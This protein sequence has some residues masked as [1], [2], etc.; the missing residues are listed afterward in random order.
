MSHSRKRPVR[1]RTRRGML[2]ESLE[3]RMVMDASLSGFVFIDSDGDGVHGSG[4]DGLPGVEITLSGTTTG[5][6]QVE[7]SLLTG[8]DGSYQFDELSAGTYRISQRQPEA[9]VDGQESSDHSGAVV[10]SDQVSNLVVSANQNVAN[11]NFAERALKP[12]YVNM[13]WF[14]ASTPSQATML[15]ESVAKGEALAGNQ[16]LADAIR[17][18][19]AEA[20]PTTTD[21]NPNQND[22]PTVAA[23]AYTVAENQTLTV[24]ASNGVLKNDSDADGDSLSASVVSAPGNGTLTLATNGSFTY[25]P[26]ADFFGTDT[27]TY[28]VNDGTVNS[29]TATVTITVT[30]EVTSQNEFTVD[31]NAATGTFV[32]QVEA[33]SS[34]GSE[35]VF[36]VADSSVASQLRLLP[37]DHYTGEGDAAALLIEYFD[38]S[39]PHCADIHAVLKQL[40]TSFSSDLLV[41]RRHLVLENNGTPIF[42][43][44]EAAA[45]A[46]EAAGRQGKFDGMVDLLLT[47]QDDWRSAA[48]PATLFNSYAQQLQLDMNQFATDQQDQAIVDRIDRDRASAADLGLS[49]TPSFFLNG[50]A[51]SNPETLSAFTTVIQTEVDSSDRV[52]ALDR[53]TGDIKVADPDSLDFETTPTFEFT[54]NA[55]GSGSESIDVTVDLFDAN[56][57]APVAQNDSY[58]AVA[59]TE[60]VVNAADGVLANDTDADSQTLYATLITTPGN[61]AVTLNE[62][63]SF[64]Y[65]PD[66]GFTGTDTFTYRA[67]DGNF[68]TA[69]VT[70]TI[71]VG[72]APVATADAYS[73]GE[74]Q[75][76]TVNAANGVLANDT[77]PDSGTLTAQ[78]ASGPSHGSLTL[79]SDG[80][81]T[82]VPEADF[83]G[84]DSFTYQASDG[85]GFSSP[86][87]V[88]ITVTDQNTF[89][90]NENSNAGVLVGTI[91]P[92]S[93][94]GDTVIFEV[95]DPN[96]P[97]ELRLGAVDHLHGDAAAPVVLIEYLDLSCPHCAD[98]HAALKQL[99]TEFAGE[100]LV[101]RRHLLLFNSSTNSFVFPN[102]EEAAFVAE[103][104][105]RQG[106][107]DEMVDL[108]FTNQD[109]WRALADPTSVFNGYA[110]QLGLD[111]TQFA[112][113]QQ[114]ANLEARI[115]RDRTSASN[116]G[117]TSTPS[118]F[119]N[120]QSISNPETV[121][122]FRSVIQAELNA[123]DEVF[124]LDR[125]TGEIFVAD[126]AELDFEVNPSFALD[127]TARGTST[128][129]IDVVIE[130]LDVAE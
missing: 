67:D 123:V 77:D 102:S 13:A 93:E 31:E 101:V 129:A 111:L 106:K 36:E 83:S 109:D 124:S 58:T 51:I 120:G 44:S 6:E 46:A 103:A 114:D 26:D 19:A 39:C 95:D 72:D 126:P 116:L 50:S 69:D 29:S 104:A 22:T 47:N 59:G 90:I 32:G 2:L 99:E 68:P 80:S 92:E 79:N 73:V 64:T 100:L 9:T 65:V 66:S 118:F 112:S 110:Q 96:M 10:G 4:E 48:S 89:S 87:T 54:V 18:G 34:L 27:F 88:A 122:G 74:D 20:P 7:Q 25:V 108:L 82:Y 30:E 127:I 24:S 105:A 130:L 78:V 41:V 1:R 60:L 16:Q 33:S 35:V 71:S 81:F 15:R 86:V 98:A 12:G 94:L 23:D 14:L 45:I 91:D 42:P 61:G 40:Q 128:E 5:G 8:N 49:S 37:D 84:D 53:L 107:F 119:L 121:Q 85:S 21:P 57:I 11:V 70:V 56:E 115:V 117:L 55:T 43:N 97:A 76:L 63:G 125:L 62:D 28:R 75:T 17:S 52:F 38:L 3:K 113:D